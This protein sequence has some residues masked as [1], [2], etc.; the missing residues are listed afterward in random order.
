MAPRSA[1][2]APSPALHPVPLTPTP[3]SWASTPPNPN[4]KQ[5]GQY[6]VL[7]V[8]DGQ[9]QP[10][11]ALVPKSILHALRQCAAP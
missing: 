5:L 9:S 1:A 4:P 6:A 2:A 3:T 7:A 8:V 10:A 11:I